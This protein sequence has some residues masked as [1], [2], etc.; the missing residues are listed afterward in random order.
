MTHF[1]AMTHLKLAL[2]S[3]LAGVIV[4]SVLPNLALS[5]T[6]SSKHDPNQPVEIVADALEVQQNDQI[7]VFSGNVEATQAN[8]KLNTARLTVHYAVGA[9]QASA[10]SNEIDK[11]EAEGGV[12]M[13]RPGEDATGDWAVYDVKG[14]VLTM[15]GNVVL[16]RDANIVRG[17]R[18]TLDL[19]SGISRIDGGVAKAQNSVPGKGRVRS[20]FTPAEKNK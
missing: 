4:L 2:F 6:K 11:L 19:E 8:L 15:G 14:R 12:V 16:T 20:L 9:K 3:L 7:A 18:L 10:E 17:A 5:A 1:K 13:S